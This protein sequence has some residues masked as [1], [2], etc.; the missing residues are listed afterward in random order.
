LLYTQPGI[1][2]DDIPGKRELG[3]FAGLAWGAAAERTVVYTDLGVS[4]GMRLGMERALFEGR[5]VEFRSLP[6]WRYTAALEEALPE[7]LS[8]W[9]P[10]VSECLRDYAR[11]LEDGSIDRAGRY[12]SRD[13]EKAAETLDRVVEPVAPGETCKVCQGTGGLVFSGVSD[14]VACHACRGEPTDPAIV[15]AAEVAQ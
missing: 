9:F 13:V 15:A 10:F 8:A 7:E 1:L 14:V 12:L 5:P 4:A 3:I 6:T 2:S 11:L